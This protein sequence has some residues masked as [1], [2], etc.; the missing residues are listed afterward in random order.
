[1]RLLRSEEGPAAGEPQAATAPPTQLQARARRWYGDRLDP[2]WRPR[3]PAASQE[4]L[5]EAGLSGPF[6]RLVLPGRRPP[7]GAR[8]PSPPPPTPARRGRRRR[9]RRRSGRCPAAPGTR[10]A[11]R[12]ARP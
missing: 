11:R 8:T 9:R 7:P 10:R 12:P 3:T 4:L 5:N 6:W 2:D 1:M